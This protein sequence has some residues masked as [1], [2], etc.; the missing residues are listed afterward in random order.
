M[1]YKNRSFVHTSCRLF[2]LHT[3]SCQRGRDSAV[4]IATSYDLDHPG[5]ESRQEQRLVS[6]SLQSIPDLGPTQP[7]VQC[8]TA[9]FPP[10]GKTA[11]AC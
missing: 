9:I 3:Q 6:S 1:V 8:V 7:P 2:H 11:G 5:I 10:M 4:G